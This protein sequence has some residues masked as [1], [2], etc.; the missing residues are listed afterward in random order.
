VYLSGVRSPDD[1]QRIR[2]TRA[3][4]ALIGETLM[5]EDDPRA[6]LAALVAAA[7]ET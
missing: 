7:R 4:A 2:R 5:R 3:H 6:L 1:V